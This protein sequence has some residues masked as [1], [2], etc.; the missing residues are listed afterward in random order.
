MNPEEYKSLLEMAFED[1]AENNPDLPTWVRCIL[2]K[3]ENSILK[4]FATLAEGDP[5]DTSDAGFAIGAVWDLKK[6]L[7]K[8]LSELENI[9]GIKFDPEDLSE[10]EEELSSLDDF[11]QDKI[12]EIENAEQSEFTAFYANLAKGSQSLYTEDNQLKHGSLD[13]E[14]SLFMLMSW[15]HIEHN[16]KTRKDC[17]HF[18]IEKLGEQRV[19]SYER[20]EKYFERIRYSPARVGRPKKP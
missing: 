11:K 19:G 6:T 14:I 20:L 3:L 18:L 9:C 13:S 7:D 2:S 17:Y 15:P 10:I 16:M 1:N 4:E 5:D 8:N 12:H